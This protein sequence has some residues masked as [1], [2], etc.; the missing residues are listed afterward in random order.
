MGQLQQTRLLGARPA[1][2]QFYHQV[3]FTSSSK[4][5][6]VNIFWYLGNFL[7][8]GGNPVLQGLGWKY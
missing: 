7:D 2:V 8:R 4:V 1:W 6:A 3:L 5:D